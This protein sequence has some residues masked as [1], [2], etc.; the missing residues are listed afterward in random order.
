MHR[1]TYCIDIVATLGA[2]SVTDVTQSWRCRFSIKMTGE[3]PRETG[4]IDLVRML[5]DVGYPG[6]PQC[7]MYNNMIYIKGEHK[8]KDT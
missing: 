4:S 7:F 8:W 6:V 2:V 5:R 3:P 1:M